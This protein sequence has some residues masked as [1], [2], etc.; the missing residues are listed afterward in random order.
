MK[1]KVEKVD[2]NNFDKSNWKTFKFEEIATKIS[3][4]VMPEEAEVDI[5]IGLEHIDGEDIYIRRHGFP[6]DVKGGKLRCYPG[7]VIFGKRR[8][9]QRKAATVDF[10]GICSAHA[11]V[12]RA[13]KD[14]IDP[15]L[16]PFF[17]HSDQFMNRMID[18]SV[19][20]LSPTI[21][22]GDLKHQEFLLPPKDM[23][24]KFL[25]IL[26]SIHDVIEKDKLTLGNLK[27][28][29]LSQLKT[30]F[31]DKQSSEN[32]NLKDVIAIKKGKC[33]SVLL[34]DGDGLPYCTLKYLRSGMIESV[35][36]PE[37]FDKVVTIKKNDLLV[38]WDGAAGDVILGKEGVLASTI[39]KV[40]IKDLSFQKYYIYQLLR[41]KQIHLKHAKTG[42]TIPH[43]DPI[44]FWS[45]KVPKISMSEQ[46]R[47][48]K[49]FMA[50]QENLGEYEKKITQ[51]KILQK[52]LIKQIF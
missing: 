30:F 35:V 4:T 25:K 47:V 24:A 9:Y 36:P 48:V 33:P 50:I 14:V 10:D 52:S 26:W 3:E 7:D 21:N 13:N 34:D 16:F 17:L 15:K 6:K 40:E 29:E 38:V 2:L 45:L 5:Y 44:V 41:S 8:A 32:I 28:L 22:W 20:G 19:G 18:I 27:Q 49:I 1:T 11:F 51:S 46:S 12:F 31:Y 37:F 39:C 43:I 23:Q 42:S